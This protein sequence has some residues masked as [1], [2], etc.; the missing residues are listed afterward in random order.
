MFNLNNNSLLIEFQSHV[1]LKSK[2]V[3][4]LD[5]LIQLINSSLMKLLTHVDVS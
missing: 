4:H 1:S 3:Q 2:L 5:D